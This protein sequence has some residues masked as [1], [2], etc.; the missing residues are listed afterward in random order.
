[1]IARPATSGV[2]RGPRFPFFF[3]VIPDCIFFVCTAACPYVPE[4]QLSCLPFFS[5]SC[6]RS[7]RTTDRKTNAKN[8]TSIRR[9]SEQCSGYIGKRIPRLGRAE[10]ADQGNCGEGSGRQGNCSCPQ[11]V[12]R[13]LQAVRSHQHSIVAIAS[14]LRPLPMRWIFRGPTW[15]V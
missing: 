14:L 3:Y 2:G 12:A 1:V 9:S 7:F 13:T 5:S 10:M 15:R 8:Q 11:Q 4:L 6:R